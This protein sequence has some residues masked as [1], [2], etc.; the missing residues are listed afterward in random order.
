MS[1]FYCYSY[2][3]LNYLH[4][5]Q[6]LTSENVAATQYQQ[7]QYNWNL[8]NHNAHSSNRTPSIANPN[9]TYQL[10]NFIQQHPMTYST[11]INYTAQTS[12]ETV[13]HAN[14]TSNSRLMSHNGYQP[15]PIYHN[16]YDL[17]PTLNMPQY[18]Q[19][20]IYHFPYVPAHAPNQLPM[21]S[22]YPEANVINLQ[23][24]ISESTT[25]HYAMSSNPAIYSN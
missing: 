2:V 25:E 19:P 13:I 17:Q 18:Y 9:Q 21:A 5:F 12:R 23:T 4:N 6:R 24:N 20:H 15:V 7:Q 14:L 8:A 10:M 3:D 22:P 1:V 16:P 11:A